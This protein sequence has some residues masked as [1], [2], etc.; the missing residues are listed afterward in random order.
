MEVSLERCLLRDSG[1]LQCLLLQGT[2][3][4]EETGRS[5][6]LKD[7]GQLWCVPLVNIHIRS[8]EYVG[9]ALV[10]VVK[11]LPVPGVNLIIGNDLAGG[12]VGTSPVVSEKPVDQEEMQ[13]VEETDDLFPVCAVTRAQ[14]RK[15]EAAEDIPELGVAHLFE[16]AL[17][18][19]GGQ[20][21]LGDHVDL[22]G[23]QRRDPELQ[24]LFQ[25]AEGE[26][27]SSTKFFLEGGILKR[28][29]QPRDCTPEDV[30][31]KKISQII[32]SKPC[33]KEVLALAHDS[34]L[35]GHLGVRKTLQKIWSTFY[36]PGTKRDVAD[37]CRTC[38]TCQLV[39]KPNARPDKAPLVPLPVFD[40]PFDRVMIDVVGPL[41]RTAAGNMYMFTLMDL[42]TRYPE[43]IPVRSTK[44]KSI[45]RELT[46]FSHALGYRRKSSL[47]RGPIS[48]LGSSRRP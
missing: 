48:C 42:A 33:R 9:R 30:E 37:Y 10:A 21:D 40:T 17:E 26:R 14:A 5:V 44:G 7:L 20:T 36:W 2:R 16:P 41:P 24:P 6:V 13:V 43:A 12:R 39:S 8:R 1:A 27:E 18:T 4:G 29:W 15:A 22:G 3:D 31:W 47:I 38:H 19:G 11:E 46:I 34:R 23:L 35:A 25:I 32:L 45:L 28:E